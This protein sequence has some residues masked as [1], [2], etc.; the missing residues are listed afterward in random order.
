[1][2]DNRRIVIIGA[3]PAG[4]RTAEHLRGE[5]WAGAI[6][7][8]GAEPHL[9]YE[10]PPLSKG[11]LI[12]STERADLTMHPAG[13]YEDNDIDVITSRPATDVDIDAHRVTMQDGSSLPFDRLLLCTGSIPRRLAVP[14][15]ESVRRALPTGP[16]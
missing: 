14:G 16:G 2:A 10:R 7:M 1:M 15:A 6:T 13:W 12:G 4:A 11:Y 8:V 5:G 9:P 3:G